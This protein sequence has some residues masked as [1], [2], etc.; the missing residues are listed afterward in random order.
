MTGGSRSRRRRSWRNRAQTTNLPTPIRRAHSAASDQSSNYSV[1]PHR[2]QAQTRIVVTDVLKETRRSTGSGRFRQTQGSPG[3]PL[4]RCLRDKALLVYRSSK[5]KIGS[6]TQRRGERP[7]HRDFS[8]HRARPAITQLQ[9][10]AR[11]Q[12]SCDH[13]TIW[14]HLEGK[15]P[16]F[17]RGLLAGCNAISGQM[18]WL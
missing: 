6:I 8:T 1:S 4:P 9:F 3:P 5:R 11:L 7:S 15:E 18:S 13:Q 12:F 17:P 2:G 14:S 10:M 16:P